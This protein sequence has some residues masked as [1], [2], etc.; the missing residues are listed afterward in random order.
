MLSIPA[1]LAVRFVAN[2]NLNQRI[3]V[4]QKSYK[5]QITG[6]GIFSSFEILNNVKPFMLINSS[7]I[8]NLSFIPI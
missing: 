8:K 2:N 1:A 4:L 5:I 6:M 3:N 7:V